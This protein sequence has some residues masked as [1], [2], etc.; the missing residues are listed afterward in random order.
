MVTLLVAMLTIIV[1]ELVPKTLALNFPER[2]ALAVARTARAAS[3]GSCAPSSG[4]SPG[5][6]SSSCASSAAS[7]RPQAGYL[8]TEELKSLVETGSEQGGIEEDEKEMIH[9]VIELGEKASTR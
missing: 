2:L 9:G 8:S 1:G 5:S 4:S 6:A 7:E 3:T